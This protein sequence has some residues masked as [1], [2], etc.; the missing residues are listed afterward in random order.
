MLIEEVLLNWTV[1]ML[2]ISYVVY[3]VVFLIV[4]Y[5]N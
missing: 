1:V 2:E 3:K 5:M 4:N